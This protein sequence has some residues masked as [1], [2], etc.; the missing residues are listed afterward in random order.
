[1]IV[2]A[3]GGGL[4][5][6]GTHRSLPSSFTVS[7]YGDTKRESDAESNECRWDMLLQAECD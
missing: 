5:V 3:F 6:L 7:N 2:R 1:M 4:F